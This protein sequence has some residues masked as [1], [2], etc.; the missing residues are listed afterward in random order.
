MAAPFFPPKG[1]QSNGGIWYA[2]YAVVGLSVI[3]FGLIYWYVRIKIIPRWK[4]YR[5]EEEMGV[6]EDGTTFTTL[7]KVM[8]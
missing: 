5:I 4:G 1:G 2:T 8:Q 7:I 3:I 6:L